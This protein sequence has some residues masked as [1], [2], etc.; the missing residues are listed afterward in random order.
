MFDYPYSAF[1]VGVVL[2][3]LAISKNGSV[4]VAGSPAGQLLLSTDRGATFVSIAER[5]AA[6]DGED[7]VTAPAAAAAV[8]SKPTATS[9][10]GATAAVKVG[11]L[12]PVLA[13]HCMRALSECSALGI[14]QHS[15]LQRAAAAATVALL[16]M[17]AIYLVKK[18]HM[19]LF[20]YHVTSIQCVAQLHFILAA[21]KP[22][23]SAN[24][25][26]SAAPSGNQHAAPG[27]VPCH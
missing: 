10:P 8:P 22:I 21:A 11:L 24:L 15:C 9:R 16:L 18:R 13:G 20:K 3:P 5:I 7:S 26:A 23:A 2:Q 6:A 1:G 4:M 17:L 14:M 12:A 25:L 27:C 19:A